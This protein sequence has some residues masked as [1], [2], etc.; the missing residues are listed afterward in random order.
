MSLGVENVSK[1]GA[2][3]GAPNR[4]AHDPL[5]LHGAQTPVKVLA[6]A[7]QHVGWWGFI[8]ELRDGPQGHEASLEPSDVWS[9]S[10]ILRVVSMI[11]AAGH[12]SVRPIGPS[13][14]SLTLP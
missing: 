4:Q 9:V 2:L 13:R 10:S 11:T 6:D 12:A 1:F 8:R 3:R 14:S 5:A 7:L